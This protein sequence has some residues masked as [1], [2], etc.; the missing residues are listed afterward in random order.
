MIP[1]P[2]PIDCELSSW[3]D[4]DT[5]CGTGIQSRVIV[6]EALHGGKECSTNR[7]SECDSGPCPIDCD[8]SSWVTTMI[9]PDMMSLDTTETPMIKDEEIPSTVM[10]ILDDTLGDKDDTMDTT[11]EPESSML[12]KVIY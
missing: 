9:S 7:T 1:K 10:T 4:C 11:M 5:I 3:S 12:P 2:S 8:L 6:Q